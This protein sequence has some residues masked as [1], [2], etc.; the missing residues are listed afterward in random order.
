MRRELLS[1][2]CK[3]CVN[4]CC[5]GHDDFPNQTYRSRRSKA[6]R[7]RDKAVEHRYARR[8]LNRKVL[9]ELVD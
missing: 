2:K 4:G 3:S 1:I 6:A 7:A 5:P 9:Q 8:I